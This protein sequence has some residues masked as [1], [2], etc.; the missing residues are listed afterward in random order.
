MKPPI[1]ETSLAY[2]VYRAARVLRQ[3]FL[4]LAQAAALDL[5]PEQ[6]F[7][8][9]KLRHRD[10]S[11]QVELSDALLSDR[12]NLTRILRGL[13]ARGWVARR[14][15][16]EDRRVKR[17]HITQAGLAT[18]DAFAE[19]VEGERERLF[20]ELAPESVATALAVLDHLEQRATAHPDHDVS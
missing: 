5:T 10:G 9:N 15:S 2:R 16:P 3:D 20:G 17:V 8:L 12:P 18:H 7:V 14:G 13:E 6:W 1:L 19:L 11:T 4:R